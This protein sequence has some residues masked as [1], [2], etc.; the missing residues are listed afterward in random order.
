M[1]KKA[2]ECIHDLTTYYYDITTDTDQCEFKKGYAY[3][4]KIAIQVIIRVF[5]LEKERKKDEH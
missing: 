2:R 1:K 4:I 3:G 5:G